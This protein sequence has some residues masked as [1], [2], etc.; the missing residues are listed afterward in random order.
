LPVELGPGGAVAAVAAVA[1]AS[2]V[3]SV[4]I[5]S[6]RLMLVGE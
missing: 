6:I 2:S 5:A 1:A 4:C 3:S